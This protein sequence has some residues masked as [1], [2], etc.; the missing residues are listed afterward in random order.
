MKHLYSLNRLATLL[1]ALLPALA[2]AQ[3]PGSLPPHPYG[4]HDAAV[5]TT[6]GTHGAAKATDYYFE[7]FDAGIGAWTVNTVSGVA[8]A[9]TSAG[10]GPTTST[11]PVPVLNS[12]TPAGWMMVDDDYLGVGLTTNASLISPV[13]DLSGAPAFLKV[14]FEQYFQEWQAESCYV[15]VSTDGGSTWSEVEINAGVGRDGRPNPELMDVD[16]SAWVAADPSNVRLRFRYVSSWDYGWQID[17]VAIREL[18][19][20]DMALLNPRLTNFNFADAGLANIDYSIYPVGQLREMQLNAVVKNKG[21]LAQT[22]IVLNATVTPPSGAGFSGSSVPYNLA[23]GLEQLAAVDGFTPNGALGTYTVNLE[24]VQD[25]VD[26]DLANGSAQLSFE[27]SEFTWAQDNGVLQSTQQQGPDFP[28]AQFEVGNFFDVQQAGSVLEGIRVALHENT[29]DGVLIYGIVYDGNLDPLVETL[30]YEVQASDLNPTGGSSFITLPLQA[31]LPLQVGE[32]YCVM[33]GCFGGAEQVAVGTSGFSVPQV[34]ILRY[35]NTDQN[36]Y[37]T[38]TPMVRAILGGVIGMEEQHGGVSTL[39]AWPNPMDGSGTVVFELAQGGRTE[40][41]L[42][43]AA[44]R[45]VLH[46]DL[47]VLAIGQYMQ[48]LDMAPLSPGLY[49][50]TVRVDGI[51]R[52]ISLARP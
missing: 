9:W 47:G 42:H 33:V 39:S 6:K 11:Y 17:N 26:D 52:G 2:I 50:A 7:D 5:V 4:R 37:V 13:I 46:R 8:W 51:T 3:S 40:L 20:N 35:P 21:Y 49:R 38:R 36:F 22:G 18:A 48:D 12:S 24:V 41:L 23:P 28:G 27:V 34:S 1:S 16:I 25:Q 30:E 19:A 32:A 14:E 43:D 15:G 44:G 29:D 45:V 31:A 10:P